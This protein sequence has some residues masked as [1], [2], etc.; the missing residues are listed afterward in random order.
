M[1]RRIIKKSCVKEEPNRDSESD[2]GSSSSQKGR[3]GKQD[4]SLSV[5]TKKFLDLIKG[6]Y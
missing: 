4:N 5:L 1:K 2:E 3:K 6:S